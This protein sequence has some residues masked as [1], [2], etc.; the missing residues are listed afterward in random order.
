MLLQHCG[1]VCGSLVRS[2]DHSVKELELSMRPIDMRKIRE[3]LRLRNC[4]KAS[5]R[6]IALSV[7][8]A[9]STV[10]EF[11]YRSDVAGLNRSADAWRTLGEGRR[12]AWIC[13]RADSSFS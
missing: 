2:L 8:L 3:V 4:L 9:R 5:R 6:E 13:R 11:F 1:F 12:S 10:A 7:G